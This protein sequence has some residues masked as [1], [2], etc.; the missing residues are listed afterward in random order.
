M[1]IYLFDAHATNGTV[2]DG[3]ALFNLTMFAVSSA[4]SAQTSR[5]IE[6]AATWG[7]AI[8]AGG[9]GTS[10]IWRKVLLILF[11]LLHHEQVGSQTWV[12]KKCAQEFIQI[13]EN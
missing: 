12:A 1:M 9:A 10:W 3:L 4:R 11:R 7:N 2:A 5:R 13:K 6:T 8:S